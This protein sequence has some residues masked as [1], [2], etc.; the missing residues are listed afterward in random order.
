MPRRK[1]TGTGPE[2]KSRET[3][4]GRHEQRILGTL[5]R[6]DLSGSMDLRKEEKRHKVGK[7][8]R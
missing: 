1:R 6:L 2:R 7:R 3:G 5:L 4:P 8:V